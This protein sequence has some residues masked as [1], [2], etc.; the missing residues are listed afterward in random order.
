MA[1]KRICACCGK[2]YEYCPTC[3]K[4]R[5]K[6][7]LA[8]TDTL[9]CKEVL[10]IISAYN[11]GLVKKYD[12]KKVL[13]KYNV[14]DFSKYKKSISDRLNELFPKVEVEPLVESNIEDTATTESS[15]KNRNWKKRNEE[16]GSNEEEK[17]SNEE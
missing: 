11:M 13:N 15:K 17:I 7:W 12:V 4:D 8:V 1:K 16:S 6:P 3:G 5:A 14:T 2:E 10:N 9:E